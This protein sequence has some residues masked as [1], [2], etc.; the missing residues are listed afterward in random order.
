MD[1]ELFENGEERDRFIILVNGGDDK[2][3]QYL[4]AK[5]VAKYRKESFQ[6]ILEKVRA[7]ENVVIQR[8]PDPEKA[9]PIVQAFQAIGTTVWV[10]QQKQISGHDVF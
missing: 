1:E 2:K 7:G 8:V 5:E 3:V 9:A 4:T 10:A 6:V